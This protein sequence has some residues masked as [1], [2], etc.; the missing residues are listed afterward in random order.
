M[1]YS[2]IV[3]VHNVE[4]YLSQCIS[5][6]LTQTYRDF[7]LIL[8][9]DG[10]CDQSGAI[11][12]QFASKDQ[13]IIAIHQSCQGVSVARN[14]GINI[15]L[16]DFIIFLDSDDYWTSENALEI[17]DEANNGTD[18][19]RFDYKIVI[20]GYDDKFV[21]PTHSTINTVGRYDSGK[22]FLVR[23][24]SVNP[25]YPWYSVMYAF[26]KNLWNKLRY[27]AGIRFHEDTAVIYKALLKAQSVNVIEDC[28]YIYRKR[29]NAVSREDSV[30]LLI[31]RVSVNQEQ[32]NYIEQNQDIEEPLKTMLCK[33]MATSFY[34]DLI[35]VGALD[36]REQE[37]LIQHLQGIQE[38]FTKY[39]A[40]KK[41]WAVN[42]MLRV[43]GIKN[44]CR[45]L[46]FRRMMKH[47][48]IMKR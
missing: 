6:V 16:G 28:I 40:T 14:V 44:T 11:C 38:Q 30:E 26:K 31:N 21:E 25:E 13:R 24:L 2:I 8:V 12:D 33:N 20:E 37:Y 35:H 46:H 47:R 19:V 5:S 48:N 7:E 18:V 9:D 10:S 23:S 17:I 4:A 3:P 39:P 34:T 45:V 27:P 15:A 29:S 22:E 32:I 1:K 36:A 43:L 41:Q 42:R